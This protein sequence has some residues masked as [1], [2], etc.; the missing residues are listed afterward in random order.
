M[1]P[2]VE[3]AAAR[4]GGEPIAAMSKTIHE[5]DIGQMKDGR[6]IKAYTLE[7][8]K[9]LRATF[10]NYGGVLVE[11]EV[12]DRI[13]MPDDVTLGLDAVE[14]YVDNNAHYFGTLVG[15][16]ANRIAHGRFSLNGKSYSLPLNE[17]SAQLHGGPEGF[18][19]KLWK[20]TVRAGPD[21]Q[22]LVLDYTSKSGE[23]GYPGTLKVRAAITLTPEN[24]L[25]YEFTATTSAPTVVNLTMH[26]Y[27]N[28]AGQESGSVR[29]HS[30]RIMA[31]QYLPTSAETNTPTGDLESVTDGPFDF[32][33]PQS[34]DH[35]LDSPNPQVDKAHGFDHT[36]V[37]RADRDLSEPVATVVEEASGR[38]ME[39]FT[40]EPGIQFYTGNALDGTLAGKN[41]YFYPRHS[42]LCLETQHFPDSPNIAKFPSTVLNPGETFSSFTEFRFSTV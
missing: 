14:D 32:R 19:H 21:G 20:G 4:H 18:S 1:R 39:V 23:M 42:G 9:G 5:E 15:R 13:G 27:F 7:N 26:P 11:L 3:C 28:L 24:G 34:L 29:N 16:F 31:D 35:R 6:P 36:F 25:R 2:V 33:E 30:V 12:P 10:L 17:E 8:D 40:S 22:V 41:G 37:L 38:K